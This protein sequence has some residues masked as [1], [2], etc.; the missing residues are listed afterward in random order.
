MPIHTKVSALKA[1]TTIHSLLSSGHYPH[2]HHEAVGQS[3]VFIQTLHATA[4]EDALAD[5]SADT[6]PELLSIREAN[7]QS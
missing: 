1:L 7:V 3:L 6:V 2:A 5:P 4:L